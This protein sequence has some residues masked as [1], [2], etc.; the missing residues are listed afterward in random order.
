MPVL[1]E[2][3]MSIAPS[4]STACICF[5]TVFFFAKLDIP[6]DN[7]IV[8]TVGSPSGIAATAS[9]EHNIIISSIV[10]LLIMAKINI[11][12][13]SE[14]EKEFQK[15]IKPTGSTFAQVMQ[16]A[17]VEYAQRWAGLMEQKIA[18]G[19]KV[20]DIAEE[21]SNE[22]DTEGITGFMYGYAVSFLSYFWE[23]GEELRL[24]HNKK[25]HHDGDGVVNPAI[26][27]SR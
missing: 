11:K 22:A 24:W 20:T 6:T 3:I 2:Q 8:I 17:S 1:S 4:V 27:C 7:V 15:Y 16:A 19:Q 9:D 21:T 13:K 18:A 10:Y 23:Y 14:K 26:L 5:T 12:I 25:Y